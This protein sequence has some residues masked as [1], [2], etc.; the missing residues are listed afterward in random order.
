MTK[1]DTSVLWGPTVAGKDRLDERRWSYVVEAPFD[2]LGEGELIGMKVSLDGQ[3]FQIRGF[4][5]RMP[6]SSIKEGELIE[7]LVAPA[8][9]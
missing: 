5:P 7:L 8:T 3:E 1:I 9:R 2:M 4:V 6:A